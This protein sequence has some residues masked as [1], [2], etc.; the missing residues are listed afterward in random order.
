M[1][2]KNEKEG[3]CKVYVAIENSRNETAYGSIY[4]FEYDSYFWLS[5][6][7]G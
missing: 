5:D 6:S 4:S 2:Y 7:R 1:N 3:F